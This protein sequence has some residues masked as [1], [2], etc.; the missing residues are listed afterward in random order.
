MDSLS[1]NEAMLVQAL[2]ELGGNATVRELNNF[3]WKTENRT[4]FV[5]AGRAWSEHY[6]QHDL[7][8]CAQ[9]GAVSSMREGARYRYFVA[10]EKELEAT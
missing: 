5:R 3:L 10:A 1:R 4:R 6:V 8:Y 7:F 2:K 9:K